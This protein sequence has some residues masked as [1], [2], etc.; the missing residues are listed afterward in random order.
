MQA[1]RSEDFFL[2]MGRG[3]R[4]WVFYG[5][6][7]VNW[8]DE[9]R[10]FRLWEWKTVSEEKQHPNEISTFNGN[11]KNNDTYTHCVVMCV[12]R[13][14]HWISTKT[15]PPNSQCIV[16]RYI[17]LSR[18]L[19]EGVRFLLFVCSRTSETQIELTLT[20]LVEWKIKQGHLF[21]IIG[22]IPTPH[23]I[24]WFRQYA[25]LFDKLG[26]HCSIITRI[27]LCEFR[28]LCVLSSKRQYVFMVYWTMR[29]SR[30]KLHVLHSYVNVIWM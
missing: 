21:R 14:M 28:I 6:Q 22:N 5:A 27:L 19:H 7:A 3:E 16:S 10:I 2:Y 12:F 8:V 24:K 13:A 11:G 17:F 4:K 29:H 20:F 9:F 15:P 30:R 23:F 25:D 26:H 1:T 18:L